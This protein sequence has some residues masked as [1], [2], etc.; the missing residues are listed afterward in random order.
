[1]STFSISER[2]L[3]P[4]CRVV[5]VVGELDL[6]VADR[7]ESAV[8]AVSSDIE[9]VVISLERCD[10]ID[11]TGLAVILAA[12]KEF[13]EAG[14]RLVVCAPAHQVERILSVTGLMDNGLVFDNVEDA[15]AG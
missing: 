14:R 10:F 5:E 7:L 3:R 12:H 4:G 6:A 9:V 8:D 13:E 1:M 2:D 11:S 15:A